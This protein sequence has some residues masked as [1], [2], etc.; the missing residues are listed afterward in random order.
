M[1]SLRAERLAEQ[2]FRFTLGIDIRRVEEIHALIER[3]KHEPI[4]LLLT[5]L[6]HDRPKTAPAERH[7]AKTNFRYEKASTAEPSVLHLPN[8]SPLNMGYA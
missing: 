7:C 1:L 3:A 4:G 5:E 8:S 2:A 6:A